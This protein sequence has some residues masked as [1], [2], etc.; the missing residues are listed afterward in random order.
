MIPALFRQIRSTLPDINRLQEAVNAVFI[1]L[2][3]CPLLDG[4][5]LS[6][7]TVTPT[8]TSFDHGLD[9]VPRG[10]IV[11]KSYT[12]AGITNGAMDERSIVLAASTSTLISIWVF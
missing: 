9:R 12:A 4:I 2:R 10:F 7:L 6:D 1:S 11:V 5:L 3:L 8:A